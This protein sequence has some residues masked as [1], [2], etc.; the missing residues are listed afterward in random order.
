M[1]ATGQFSLAGVRIIARGAV[2]SELYSA[3][4]QK[5]ELSEMAW[6]L[7]KTIKHWL[8]IV[9]RAFLMVTAES[10]MHVSRTGAQRGAPNYDPQELDVLPVAISGLAQRFSYNLKNSNKIEQFVIKNI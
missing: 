9:W 2:H 8:F 7:F 6:F 4:T 3:R 5:A 10:R 1:Y